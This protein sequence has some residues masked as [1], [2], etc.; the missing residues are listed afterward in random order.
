MILIF[1]LYFRSSSPP[2]AASYASATVAGYV[3]C[4]RNSPVLLPVYSPFTDSAGFS[5][6][7][8]HERTVTVS[9]VTA[10]T[11]HSARAK[12]HQ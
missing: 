1:L 6:A 4:G 2:Q 7:A 12:T 9:T 3:A 11:A 10:S 8:R 5:L